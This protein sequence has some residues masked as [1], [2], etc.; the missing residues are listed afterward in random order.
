[1]EFDFSIGHI[2]RSLGI[3]WLG[4]QSCLNG[5]NRFGFSMIHIAGVQEL[6]DLICRA[7]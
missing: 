7:N 4:V 1:M 6:G 3:W 2:C 5:E